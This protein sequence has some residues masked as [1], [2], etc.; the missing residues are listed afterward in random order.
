M[1]QYN[2][3]STFVLEPTTF[4]LESAIAPFLRPPTP[5]RRERVFRP[6]PDTNVPGADDLGVVAAVPPE[7]AVSRFQPI[8]ELREGIVVS[9]ADAVGAPS[10]AYAP[11]LIVPAFLVAFIT[12][13][14]LALFVVHL[15]RRNS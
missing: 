4:T 9:S 2:E 5:P 14:G 15:R 7:P 3:A 10:G 8:S 1:P 13:A 12:V 11:G 6:R